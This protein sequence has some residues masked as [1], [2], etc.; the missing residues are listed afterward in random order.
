MTIAAF[1]REVYIGLITYK[2][3]MTAIPDAKCRGIVFI[4]ITKHYT[5]KF[6]AYIGR[7]G[8]SWTIA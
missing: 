8:S 4:T 7:N 6:P 1:L 2:Q 5:M 3:F